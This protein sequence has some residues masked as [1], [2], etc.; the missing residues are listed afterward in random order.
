MGKIDHA[1][2]DSEKEEGGL[3][4]V[5]LLIMRISPMEVGTVQ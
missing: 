5:S 4:K 2:A 3:V 1:E